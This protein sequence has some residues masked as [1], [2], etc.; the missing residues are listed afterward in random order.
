MTTAAALIVDADVVAG[1]SIAAIVE[2]GVI[3]E[4]GAIVRSN[5]GRA[6]QWT[7]SNCPSAASVGPWS[8]W[9]KFALN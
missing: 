3:A 8:R 4:T 2:T 5:R 6:N 7:A 9:N 1:G